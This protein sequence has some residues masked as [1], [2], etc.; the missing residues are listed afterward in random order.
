MQHCKY[1][2]ILWVPPEPHFGTGKELRKW[3]LANGKWNI[4]MQETVP[5]C[6]DAKLSIFIS[7]HQNSL[8]FRS[9]W[10]S[11]IALFIFTTFE[12]SCLLFWG[13]RTSDVVKC[14]LENWT[15]LSAEGCMA[16]VCVCS[17]VVCVCPSVWSVGSPRA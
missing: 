8:L 17:L 11:E 3:P 9:S 16:E 15:A 13:L 2:A 14:F 5:L 6:W 4:V 12:S 10:N 7:S 1:H